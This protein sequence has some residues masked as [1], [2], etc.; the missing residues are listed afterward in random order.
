MFFLLFWSFFWSSGFLFIRSFWI[1]L[2]DHLDLT[3]LDIFLFKFQLNIFLEKGCV[4]TCRLRKISLNFDRNWRRQLFD[5]IQQKFS[6]SGILAKRRRGFCRQIWNRSNNLSTFDDLVKSQQ[7]FDR[8]NTLRRRV[9]SMQKQT[10]KWQN[11]NLR[12]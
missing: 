3:L 1:D 7:F 8:V 6:E 9:N 10:C 11:L 5:Q 4:S 2:L 12:K